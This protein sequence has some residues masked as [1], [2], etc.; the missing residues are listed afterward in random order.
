MSVCLCVSVCESLASDSSE[1]IEVIVLK[2]GTVTTSDMG[3]N[4]SRVNGNECQG[5]TDLN[6][7]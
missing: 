5:H 6:H 2:C 7:E 4:A 1:T 3:T